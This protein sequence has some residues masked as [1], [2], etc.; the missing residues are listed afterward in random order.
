MKRETRL[1]NVLFPIWALFFFPQI[2][3]ILLPANFLIDSL[4]LLA[5]MAALHYPRKKA[6]WKSAILRVWG[7]GFA[8]DLAGSVVTLGMCY[9]FTWA[10]P[11]L[12]L[13]LIPGAQLLVLPGIAVSGV[14]I[15][16][17]NRR[18]SFRRTEMDPGQVRRLSL[19]LAVCTAPYTMLIPSEWIY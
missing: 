7:I 3:L 6:V 15:Y 8:C 5:G 14:L 18:L 11:Q 17:L 1:Y 13:F 9:L 4:V 16:Q 19:I 12:N 2:W 10:A